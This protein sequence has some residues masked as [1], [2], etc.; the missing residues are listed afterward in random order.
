MPRARWYEPLLTFLAEQPPE[1]ASVT[2]TVAELAT[3][4]GNRLPATAVTRAYW[5][6]HKQGAIADRLGVTGWRVAHMRGRPPV[7]TFMRLSP[8]TIA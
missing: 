8:D 6:T 2:L 4:V 3:L 7:I 1:M 5:W